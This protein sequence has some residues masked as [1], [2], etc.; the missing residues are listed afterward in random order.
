MVEESDELGSGELHSRENLFMDGS[1]RNGMR[2]LISTIYNTDATLLAATRFS[3]D[4]V[5][6]LVT[7]DAPKE[8][9]E[10]VD[11]VKRSIGTVLEF[12]VKKI[13][14]YDVVEVA[15]IVVDMID[16]LSEE[17]ELTLN[18]TS[19]RKTQAIGVMF[20]GYARASRI[21]RIV[22]L[23][24]DTKQI[25]HLPI[26]PFSFNETEKALLEQ[27]DQGKLKTTAEL[28]EAIERSPAMVYR[29]L[30]ELKRNDYVEA[31]DGGFKLTDAGRIARL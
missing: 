27:I 22:Y 7:K 12:T 23:R 3:P 8:Q 10:A 15:R 6:G 19:G 28:A 21:R 2:I 24:E 31:L 14:E 20:A 18:V 17:D 29:A 13:P 1:P 9:L 4:R 25:V 5:I 16:T 30:D 26:V 11:L